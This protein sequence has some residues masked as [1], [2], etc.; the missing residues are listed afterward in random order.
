MPFDNDDKSEEYQWDGEQ[1]PRISDGGVE[2]QASPER[3]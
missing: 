1:T 2:V 3:N